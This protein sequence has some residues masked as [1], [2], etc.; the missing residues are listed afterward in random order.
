ML[1]Q[2]PTHEV[3]ATVARISSKGIRQTFGSHR[4]P[5]GTAMQRLRCIDKEALSVV[6][7]DVRMLTWNTSEILCENTDL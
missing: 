3:S 4:A 5:T 1:L 7:S 2:S 6:S